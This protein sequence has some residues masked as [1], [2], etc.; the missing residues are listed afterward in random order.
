MQL[1]SMNSVSFGNS[2]AKTVR[3]LRRRPNGEIV[4]GK[5]IS[6]R[7]VP[8]YKNAVGRLFPSSKY[9][10]VPEKSKSTVRKRKLDKKA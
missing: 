9:F 2:E 10:F 6:Q 4:R 3:V 8:A 1:N 7:E 5:A